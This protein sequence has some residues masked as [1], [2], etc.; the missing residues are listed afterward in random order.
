MEFLNSHGTMY[1]ELHGESDKTILLIHGFPLDSSMWKP[2]IPFLVKSGY[3]VL[4]LDLPGLGQSLY[5][6][7]LS[8][9]EMADE[10]AD[11]LQTTNTTP[12]CV[13]GMSMGG[14]VALSLAL[15]HPD[16]F[17]KLALIVTRAEADSEEAREGRYKLAEEVRQNGTKAAADIFIDKVLDVDSDPKLRDVVYSIMT[18]APA[19]G[20][21]AALEAMAQ[22]PDRIATLPEIDALTLVMWAEKDKAM[23]PESARNMLTGIADASEARLPGG[24]LT[25]MEYPEEF[26]RALLRFLES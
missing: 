25:N 4:L 11:M 22:R 9:D 19:A 10:I 7:A 1:Y 16:C 6:R 15:R 12:C 21:V 23:P 8:I 14:Y 5:K 26:N 20:V 3:S 24:H 13:G 2:Q 18:K 17:N